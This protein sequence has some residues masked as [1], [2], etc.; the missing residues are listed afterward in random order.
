MH[1]TFLFSWPAL[2]TLDPDYGMHVTQDID[3]DPHSYH[4][5]FLGKPHT[6][7]WVAAKFVDVY[8]YKK[9]GK[10]SD[11]PHSQTIAGKKKVWY[12]KLITAII[13]DDFVVVFV[14]IVKF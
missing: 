5:E 2:I 7:C 9:Q 1:K 4:V 3:G 14:V 6:H 11:F 10:G 13:P 12:N 8:G